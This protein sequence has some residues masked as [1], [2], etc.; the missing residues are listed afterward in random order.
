MKNL[1]EMP[2]SSSGPSCSAPS[3]LDQ[4][5]EFIKASIALLLEE[6]DDWK[7]YLRNQHATGAIE[8]AKAELIEKMWQSFLATMEKICVEIKSPGASD[9]AF[10]N[11][12]AHSLRFTS[13]FL[14]SSSFSSV[15]TRQLGITLAPP[16]GTRAAI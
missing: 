9:R 10:D 8:R 6:D 15:P 1:F 7:R 12:L 2:G 4:L 14:S 5:A 16:I 3:L 13:P 11:D